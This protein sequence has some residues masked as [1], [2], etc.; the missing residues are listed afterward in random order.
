MKRSIFVGVALHPRTTACAARETPSGELQQRMA[1]VR[2][3]LT[4]F[5]PLFHRRLRTEIKKG[6]QDAPDSCLR[7]LTAELKFFSNR[8][9][10][11][12]S[13]WVT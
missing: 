4:S 11:G 7:T 5:S 8:S 9:L 13:I 2:R 10:S 3:Q 12:F 6:A 1:G